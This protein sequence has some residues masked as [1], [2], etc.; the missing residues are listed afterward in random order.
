[1]ING[2][3][4][5]VGLQFVDHC[6]MAGTYFTQV[7]TDTAWVTG[8]TIATVTKT[9]SAATCDLAATTAAV[10]ATDWF[11]PD[12]TKVFNSAT[13]TDAVTTVTGS[14]WY[15]SLEV[16]QQYSGITRMVVNLMPLLVVVAMIGFTAILWKAKGSLG[17]Q[18]GSIQGGIAFAVGSLIV[19]LIA[20]FLLPTI[21]QMINGFY[22]SLNPQRYNVMTQF[23]SI[24]KLVVGFFPLLTVVGAV[25]SVGFL[26]SMSVN[27]FR[28]SSETA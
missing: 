9:A 13:V 15:P 5:A 25:G 10:A 19:L 3:I 28:G 17:A 12:G 6:R 26:G 20:F 23:G 4:N 14:Q 21:F 8:S 16:L 7:S 2:A 22:L 11:A 24:M 1:M 18:S 27:M